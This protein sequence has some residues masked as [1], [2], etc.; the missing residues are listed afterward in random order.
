MIDCSGINCPGNNRF[1][2]E[3]RGMEEDDAPDED[4]YCSE[5]CQKCRIYG[6][7]TCHEDLEEFEP[8]VACDNK[9]CR[10]E[11]FHYKCVGLEMHQVWCEIISN[12]FKF[13]NIIIF[14]N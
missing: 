8:M 1:H 7:C 2:L 12:M 10:L 6:Y 4:F 3:C 14:K 11:W 5:E 13:F 9:N